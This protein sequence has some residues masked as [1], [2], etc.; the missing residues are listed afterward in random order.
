MGTPGIKELLPAG[1][2]L[3]QSEVQGML[4]AAA[5]AGVPLP[6]RLGALE[7]WSRAVGYFKHLTQ[8]NEYFR[9]PDAELGVDLRLQIN[10][11]RL[12]YTPPPPSSA[13]SC[14]LCIEN[15]GIPGKELLRVHE[16][17][18]AGVAYFFQLTPFPLC[19]GHYVG[20]C[21]THEP[22]RI[23]APALMESADFTRQCAGWLVASNSDVAWA[24]ASVL[25]HHHIQ[26]FRD[27]RLPVE[28]AAAV[29]AGRG[30]GFASE[31]L[32]WPCPVVRL[33]GERAAV[34]AEAAALVTRW[35]ATDPGSATCNYLMRQTPETLT[36]HLFFRHPRYRT[37]EVLRGIKSEGV[38][39]IEMAGE[40][41]V[42]PLK[43][44]TRAENR[45]Y[46]A[47][48]GPDIVRGIIAGNGPFDERLTPEWYSRFCGHGAEE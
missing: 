46:F 7:N 37:P 31:F 17:P 43:E 33:S 47:Q 16:S 1:E 48:H 28:D 11:S 25:G 15:I 19:D 35:K 14:P 13:V 38:G 44:K 36:I 4:A 32:R 42:P 5:E 30:S 8:P 24:G 41:I 39:I 3:P 9:F 20:N 27:L 12:G 34:L 6:E 23:A 40:V 22:M 10:Y 2:A 29:S 26:I 45:A 18:L 21:R